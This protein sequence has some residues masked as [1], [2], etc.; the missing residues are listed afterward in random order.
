MKEKHQ[1]GK[2][3]PKGNYC[4]YELGRLKSVGTPY[5]S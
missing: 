3:K 1:K 2:T 4:C 5:Y